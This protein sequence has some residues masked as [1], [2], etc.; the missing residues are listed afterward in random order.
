MYGAPG[1]YDRLAALGLWPAFEPE[2]PGEQLRVYR[3]DPP[4]IAKGAWWMTSRL[5][6]ML[7]REVEAHGSRFLVA[8]IPNRMEV[9]DRD[10]ELSL[11]AHGLDSDEWD[12]NAVRDRLASTGKRRGFPVL[13]LG[14]AL[15]AADRGLLGEPYFVRDDHW[16]ALGHSVAAAALEDDLRARGW[17]PACGLREKRPGPRAP[18]SATRGSEERASRR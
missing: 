6:E 1:A 5:L 12:R 4:P 18:V 10:W 14:P 13:D 3:K 11:R 9:V 15:S 17:L 2:E 7:A 8:Y 16:N